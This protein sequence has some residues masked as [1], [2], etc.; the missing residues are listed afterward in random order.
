VTDDPVPCRASA[1]ST[2]L[3]IVLNVA[4]IALLAVGLLA[5]LTPSEGMPSTRDLAVFAAGPPTLLVTA[6]LCRTS[7]PVRL[8]IGVECVLVLALLLVLLERLFETSP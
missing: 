6:F 1:A 7:K 8:L 2:A 5:P 3:A 4:A